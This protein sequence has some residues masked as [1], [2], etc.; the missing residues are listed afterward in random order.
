[1]TEEAPDA[2]AFLGA[3]ERLT[4]QDPRLTPLQAGIVTASRMGIANDTRTF[5][6]L[7]GVEHALALRELNQLATLGDYIRITQRDPRT[8]RTHYTLSAP[9]PSGS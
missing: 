4:A 5:A 7:L 8:M 1:M 3:V 9:A 2:D 6:R